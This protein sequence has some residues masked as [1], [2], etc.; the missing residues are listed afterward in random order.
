MIYIDD[1]F[2]DYK[3]IFL[4]FLLQGLMTSTLVDSGDGV[5]HCIPVVEGFIKKIE[6]SEDL[7]IFINFKDLF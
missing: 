1:F 5:T 2:K 7:I 6:F 4:S 3:Y